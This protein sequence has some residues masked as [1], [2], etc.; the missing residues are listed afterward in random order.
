MILFARY[1]VLFNTPILTLGLQLENCITLCDCSSVIQGGVQL[2]GP[3]LLVF[4]VNVNGWLPVSFPCLSLRQRLLGKVTPFHSF[5]A[6]LRPIVYLS[7]SYVS[8]CNLTLVIIFFL[9]LEALVVSVIRI[10]FI[11]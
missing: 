6:L 7:P 3:I 8:A 1:F 11:R 9:F 10:F 4:H 5:N 2:R